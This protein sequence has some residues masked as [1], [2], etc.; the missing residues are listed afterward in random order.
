MNS[1]TLIVE[2]QSFWHPGTGRGSGFYLDAM[3]HAGSD[4]LPRLPGR[5]L[6]GLLRDALWRAEQWQ[7]PQVP[8][9]A[10]WTL[11]GSRDQHGDGETS[12]VNLSEPGAL[13][14]GDACL[15]TEVADY[16]S[17]TTDGR[18]LIQGLYREHFSTAIEPG[19]GVAKARSLRGIQ[20]IVPLTLEARISEVPGLQAKAGWRETLK[21]V[22]P[23]ITAVGAH[24]TRGFGRARLSWKEAGPHA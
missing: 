5:T 19:T 2:I 24:R 1:A 10:T 12:D 22:L 11:F 21:A 20:V 9:G 4:G 14:V 3:T 15:P 17:R 23:L 13:R 18:A 6:K 7:W 8:Q 16:L